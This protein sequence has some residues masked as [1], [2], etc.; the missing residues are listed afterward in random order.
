[1]LAPVLDPDTE[2]LPV[3]DPDTELLTEPEEFREDELLAL[4]VALRVGRVPVAELDT[5]V[6]RLPEPQAE[7]LLLRVPLAE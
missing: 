4:R 2:T 1:V 7:A 3:L 5:V 6:D